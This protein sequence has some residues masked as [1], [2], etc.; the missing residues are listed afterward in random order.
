MDI[1]NNL[2]S[3]L[4]P[5]LKLKLTDLAMQL[6][7]LGLATTEI[8]EVGNDE[9][10]AQGFTILKNGEACG[11]FSA[12][13]VDALRRGNQLPGANILVQFENLQGEATV[14]YAPCNYTS[15]VFT[16]DLGE[17]KLR[18][19]EFDAVEATRLFAVQLR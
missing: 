13:A 16:T 7:A 3:A 15:S 17:L 4:C 9:E 8:Q 14:V 18:L 6:S 19:E 12:T 11:Y 10:S 1:Y 2:Y 5:F